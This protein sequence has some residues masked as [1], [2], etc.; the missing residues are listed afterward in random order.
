M[1]S[2]LAND[3]LHVSCYSTSQV[4]LIIFTIY[5]TAALIRNTMIFVVVVQR[6]KKW[7]HILGRQYCSGVMRTRSDHIQLWKWHKEKVHNRQR[8]QQPK[9]TTGGKRAIEYVNLVTKR[10]PWYLSKWFYDTFTGAATGAVP[11]WFFCWRGSDRTRSWLSGN[12]V[13]TKIYVVQATG[14]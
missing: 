2:V 12:T 9:C 6:I 14:A 5:M 13:D 1:K 11:L 3:K 8:I 7:P 10:S 4:F